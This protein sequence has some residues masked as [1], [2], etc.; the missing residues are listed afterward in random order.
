MVWLHD[1]LF[2]CESSRG[3]PRSRPIFMNYDQ[4]Y[5]PGRREIGSTDLLE[6]GL[7][8]IWSAWE[9]L[10][11]RKWL[12]AP[13][14]YTSTVAAILMV[15]NSA[16]HMSTS[17]AQMTQC[18]LGPYGRGVVE[19][20]GCDPNDVDVLMGTLTKSFAA[21]GGY[22][23]GKKSTIEYVRAFSQGSCYGV[24]MSPPLIAQVSRIIKVCSLFSYFS[25]NTDSVE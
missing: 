3:R 23:A 9:A 24:V 16:K 8:C 25:M 14:S 21:A 18:A 7:R 19:Y 4:K 10:A 5:V 20:W 1:G 2:G 17:V 13:L 15:C 11:R 6:L 12:I 22:I